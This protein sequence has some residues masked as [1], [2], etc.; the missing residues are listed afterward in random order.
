MITRSATLK[1]KTAVG[2]LIS[3]VVMAVLSMLLPPLGVI[4]NSVL[5]IFAQILIYA[6]SAFGI[7]AYIE[8]KNKESPTPSPP[9]RGG[10]EIT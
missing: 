10:S 6:G 4:D 1:E 3:G 2:M 8:T 7:E 9:H 5:Y